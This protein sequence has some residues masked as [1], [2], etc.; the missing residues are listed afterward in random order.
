MANQHDTL[1]RQWHM[2]RLM[3]RYP[4]KVT[5][6]AVLEKLEADGFTVTKRTVERDLNELSSTFPLTLDD[7]DKPYGWSWQKDAPSFDL[8]GIG[9][10]EALTLVMVEQHLNNLLPNSTV[11]V[12][13]PYFKSAHKHL[14]ATTSAQHVKSWLSKVRTVQP[15]QTL[16]PPKI[17][18]EVQQLISEALLSDRQVEIE[19]KRRNE[20]KAST[21]RIHP[22][23]LIQR[24]GLIY[25]YVR[26]FD[27]EDIKIIALHRIKSV[28]ILDI[29]TIAPE[30]FN[31]DDEITQGRFD[32]G[33][34]SF[35]ELEVKFTA[36]AGEHLFETPLSKEQHID[37][38]DDGSLLVRA[39]VPDTP[40][41]L[42][43]LL[44]FGDGVEVLEPLAIRDRISAI[45]KRASNR[46][47]L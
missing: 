35:I 18:P 11:D 20:S 2:L 9:A 26:Y 29:A 7:R 22:L 40:Q 38:L 31:I 41:L 4:L 39:N 25:L 28:K 33:T 12:L 32:F 3:P 16:L 34:G 24:G 37:V 15:S 13:K 21:H 17:K 1:L 8:P 5:A 43:W 27:Y 42:W 10:N 19:Y 44:G 45:L 6:R 14:D 36:E 46:Y 23:A 47:Q 30:G